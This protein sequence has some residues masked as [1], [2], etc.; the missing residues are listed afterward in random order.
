MRSRGSTA[1][2][3]TMIPT[4]PIQVVNCRHMAIERDCA[5]MSVS[6]LDPVVEKPDID[7]NSAS[8]G[9]GQLR[10]GEQVRDRAEDRDQQPDQGDD[11]IAL[12]SADVLPSVGQPLADESGD[13]RDHAGDEER[14]HRLAVADGERRGEEKRGAR[15]L[16]SQPTRF[17]APETSTPMLRGTALR[18]GVVAPIAPRI[19]P[20]AAVMRIVVLGAGHVG[21]ALVERSAHDHEL[22]V[23]RRRRRPARH[24]SRAL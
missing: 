3:S 9:S 14:P 19:I 6:T 15:Y 2:N 17:N 12:T 8:T 16:I 23:D 13:E 21:R 11:E 5:S 22:V 1:K 24:A 18:R 20:Y 4:P 7:S 10:L